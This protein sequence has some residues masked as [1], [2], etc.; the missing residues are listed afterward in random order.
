MHWGQVIYIPHLVASNTLNVLFTFRI[1]GMP[2]SSF[3]SYT[4]K[5]SLSHFLIVSTATGPGFEQ[6]LVLKILNKKMTWWKVRRWHNS[7]RDISL[8]ITKVNLVVGLQDD[9]QNHQAS[10]NLLSVCTKCKSIFLMLRYFIKLK[11][12]PLVLQDENHQS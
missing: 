12:V 5:C 7:C 4:G 1:T 11:A 9:H 3:F 10:R 2:S 8:Y 6:F